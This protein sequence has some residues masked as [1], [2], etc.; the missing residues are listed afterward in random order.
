M[1]FDINNIT[2]KGVNRPLVAVSLDKQGNILEMKI[3]Q[4]EQE[5]AFKNAVKVREYELKS[6]L[7]F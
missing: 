4:P 7:K 3:M 6:Y 2:M 1:E 5:Y